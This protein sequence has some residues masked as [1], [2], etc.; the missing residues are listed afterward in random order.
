MSNIGSEKTSHTADAIRQGFETSGIYGAVV[1]GVGNMLNILPTPN[2]DL[3]KNTQ[4]AGG[5]RT[6]ASDALLKTGDPYL[7]GAAAAVKIL[8]KTGGFSDA[9]EGLGGTNDTLNTLAS[10]TLP[11]AG[12]FTKPIEKYKVSADTKAM[13]NSYSGALANNTKAARNSEG[14]ILFGRGKAISMIHK[15]KAND[16]LISGIK[17][18][19][20]AD[21]ETMS[22]MTQAKAMANQ[23]NYMGGYNQALA[24][25]G[26]FGMKI[27]MA[28]RIA[29]IKPVEEIYA[30]K[31]GGEFEFKTPEDVFTPTTPEQ[32]NA[33]FAGLTFV[34]AFQE[35]GQLTVDDIKD[36]DSFYKYL[37]QTDRTDPNFDYENFYK[38]DAYREDWL[39]REKKTPGKAHMND[40]YKKPNHP[41]YSTE[42]KD[43]EEKGG[44][45]TGSDE[46][47]WTFT[48][49]PFNMSQYTYEDY[50]KYW[51]NNEPNSTLIYGEN[52]IT[53]S[54]EVHKEGGQM[55]VIPEGCLHARLHHMENADDLTRK[56]IPVVDNKG[57]QQA[58]IECN[59]IIFNLE[60]TQKLEEW[61]KAFNKEDATQ[62]EKDELAIKAGKLLAKEIM[63]NTDDRTGLINNI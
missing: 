31:D 4:L 12:W 39:E 51:P 60:V 13:L 55:N 61:C 15:A 63:E 18:E 9:S 38:D 27:E 6:G 42:S 14:K 10:M 41:T 49:S 50:Q 54:V 1:Q 24:R 45:W 46:E 28:K 8:D 2:A 7:M 32:D 16:E 52:V 3:N 53:P 20:D 17:S 5:I 34:E 57:N 43:G 22:T 40:Y 35:G 56:G 47:G 36:F 19:S 44:K 62:K 21:Y 29:A 33:F 23:Y 25:A 37:S 48:A 30:M 58:E 59:E 26:K 11:G